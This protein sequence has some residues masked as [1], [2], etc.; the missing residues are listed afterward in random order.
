MNRA[1]LVKPRQDMD[2]KRAR[3]RVYMSRWRLEHPEE[4]KARNKAYRE[5]YPEKVAAGKKRCYERNPSLYIALREKWK[6]ANRAKHDAYHKQYRQ[7]EWKRFA[8][9]NK[10][11]RQRNPDKVL[12]DIRL[13]NYRRRARM[14]GVEFEY[15]LREEIFLRDNGICWI[16]GLKVDESHWHLDHKIPVVKGGPHTRSNVAVSHPTCNNRKHAKIL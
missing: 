15:F 14:A 16:C 5:A 7:D 6:T 1:E 2:K 3:N 11:Y 9:A 12:R 10:R 8:E 13:G 4:A